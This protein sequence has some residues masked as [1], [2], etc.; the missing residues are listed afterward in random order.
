MDGTAKTS[1]KR[2]NTELNKTHTIHVRLT[3]IEK[4]Q[5]E[6]LSETLLGKPNLSRLIRILLRE[7]IG[8]G[9]DLLPKEREEFSLAIRQLTGIARNLNQITA[10]IH[11]DKNQ[12]KRFS[13]SNIEGLLKHVTSVRDT[14]K[15]VILSSQKRLVT[16][17]KEKK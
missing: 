8:A 1:R 16:I 14:L 2:A 13:E 15:Q 7:A 6:I 4:E 17:N 12:I 10:A 9:P 11:S 5:G 3:P